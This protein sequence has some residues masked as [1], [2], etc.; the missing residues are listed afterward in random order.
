MLEVFP[1]VCT[2]TL[3]VDNIVFCVEIQIVLKI[4]VKLS[5]EDCP[6]DEYPILWN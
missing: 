1:D 2:V 3:L 6:E 4:F 5:G